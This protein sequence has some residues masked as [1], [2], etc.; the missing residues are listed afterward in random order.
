M[1]NGDIYFVP[2]KNPELNEQRPVTISFTDRVHPAVYKAVRIEIVA[3]TLSMEIVP[4]ELVQGNFVIP[5]GKPYINVTTNGNIRDIICQLGPPKNGELL[6]DS[7]VISSI[8]PEEINAGKL[9]YILKNQLA[10]HDKFTIE[11]SSIL[12][13]SRSDT[14]NVEI[15]SGLSMKNDEIFILNPSGLTKFD[16]SRIQMEKLRAYNPL[17]FDVKNSDKLKFQKIVAEKSNLTEEALGFNFLTINH[18]DSEEMS[19]SKIF[20]RSSL[21]ISEKIELLVSA[22]GLPMVLFKMPVKTGDEDNSAFL[23]NFGIKKEEKPTTQPPTPE[24]I[25]EKILEKTGNNTDEPVKEIKTIS[26]DEKGAYDSSSAS[27]IA[28]AKDDKLALGKL[29]YII[30]IAIICVLIIIFLGVLLLMRS[31]RQSD[32]NQKSHLTPYTPSA[33]ISNVKTEE[34]EKSTTYVIAAAQDSTVKVTVGHN[35]YDSQLPV[36]TVRALSP[37]E[38]V[39][40]GSSDDGGHTAYAGSNYFGVMPMSNYGES[41]VDDE[42]ESESLVSFG[43]QV[44]SHDQDGGTIHRQQQYWV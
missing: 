44:T 36:T 3:L 9:V 7:K 30:P 13:K 33:P 26:L 2:I 8:T 42:F 24:I 16:D 31:N 10:A 28:A 37:E 29:L 12:G 39:F 17:K 19:D 32:D 21:N 14:L 25:P 23:P 4:V 1:E 5:L 18:F 41:R 43:T 15:V 38:S 35:K 27:E 6:T 34:N 40:G 20:I 11:C 22:S